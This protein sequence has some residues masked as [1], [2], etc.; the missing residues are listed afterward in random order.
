MHALCKARITRGRRIR[1]AILKTNHRHWSQAG[2]SIKLCFALTVLIRQASTRTYWFC[3]ASNFC[4]R[5]V[6]H[7]MPLRKKHTRQKTHLRSS[8]ITQPSSSRV[9][10]HLSVGLFWALL[11]PVL[12]QPHVYLP[13]L[14]CMWVLAVHRRHLQH[15]DVWSLGSEGGHLVDTLP[16]PIP[17]FCIFFRSPLNP[18][19]EQR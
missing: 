12:Q 1:V 5:S 14:C 19:L 4:Q 8:A 2:E 18:S 17:E 11:M 9:M 13:L 7:S 16:R 6:L 15:P 3:I 10:D